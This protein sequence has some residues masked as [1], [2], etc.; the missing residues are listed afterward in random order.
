M[1]ELAAGQCL[2]F[3][4][5]GRHSSPAYVTVEKIGRKWAQISNGYRIGVETWMAD[6]GQY[7]SPGSCW[8]S[9]EAWK[10]EAERRNAWAQ[11]RD[12]V[13]RSYSAPDSLTRQQIEELTRL[14]TADKEGGQ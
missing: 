13:D 9:E 4:P 6:G 8:E 7:M 10:S 2:W 5:N 11:F 3:V 12:V 14:L 1:K